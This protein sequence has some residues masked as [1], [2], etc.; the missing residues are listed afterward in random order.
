MKPLEL[1]RKTESATTRKRNEKPVLASVFHLPEKIPTNLEI[2]DGLAE[3]LSLFSKD[4]LSEIHCQYLGA[5]ESVMEKLRD[6]S[7]RL[8]GA[9]LSG[10][11]TDSPSD[12]PAGI[13]GHRGRCFIA[14][15]RGEHQAQNF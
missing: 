14:A 9:A 15:L 8:T 13:F 12:R 2:E 6:F 11:I 1:W 3:H 10:T 4:K 7:P 5:A